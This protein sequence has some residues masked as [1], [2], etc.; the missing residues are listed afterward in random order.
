MTEITLSPLGMKIIGVLLAL[1][2]GG[3]IYWR[4]LKDAK[5][6]ELDKKIEEGERETK[7]AIQGIYK[8][9]NENQTQVMGKL[10]EVLKGQ[11]EIEVKMQHAFNKIDRNKE[12]LDSLRRQQSEDNKEIHKNSK[13][14]AVLGEWQKR[15]ESKLDL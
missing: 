3:I 12:N 1:V 7:K 6:E 15:V 8:A 11:H 2:S 10:D 14:L 13:S 9:Q 5:D 4:K